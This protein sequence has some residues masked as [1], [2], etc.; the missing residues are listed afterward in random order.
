M[1]LNDKLFYDLSKKT[2]RCFS[3]IYSPQPVP[4]FFCTF[5]FLNW[6]FEPKNSVG[7]FRTTIER[8]EVLN[9][10]RIYAFMCL[11]M[12]VNYGQPVSLKFLEKQ[13]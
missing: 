12:S 2:I 3:L 1:V 6:I 9:N 10:I 5:T 8:Y 11:K 4:Y 13:W 7:G